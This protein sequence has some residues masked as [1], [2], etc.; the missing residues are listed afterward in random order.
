MEE[1][2]TEV[3]FLDILCAL[4]TFCTNV[5]QWQKIDIVKIIIKY[6]AE[7]TRSLKANNPDFF[8]I[9]EMSFN[10]VDTNLEFFFQSLLTIS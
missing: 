2:Y 9:H 7:Q 10:N 5:A 4:F 3:L 1:I 6:H 8:C